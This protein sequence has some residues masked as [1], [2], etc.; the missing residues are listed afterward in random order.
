M[1]SKPLAIALLA[2]LASAIAIAPAEAQMGRRWPPEKKIVPD[3]VTGV[4][5]V[6]LTS[7][8]PSVICSVNRSQLEK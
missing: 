2:A 6:F 5:L 1:R 4:P 3:P 8:Q 7:P